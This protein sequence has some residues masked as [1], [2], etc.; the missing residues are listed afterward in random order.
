MYAD[1]RHLRLVAIGPLE[2]A[3]HARLTRS[4]D[5]AGIEL[6]AFLFVTQK[7]VGGRDGLEILLGGFVVRIDIWVILL[8][9]LAIGLAKLDPAKPPARHQELCKGLWP[10][11]ALFPLPKSIIGAD[12]HM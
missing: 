8:G 2:L 12:K 4:V 1:R 5:R 10:P 6:R 7:V 11:A 9:Q 3:I